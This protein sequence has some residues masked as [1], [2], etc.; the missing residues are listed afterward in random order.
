VE[1]APAPLGGFELAIE[2]LYCIT[3]TM[4]LVNQFPFSGLTPRVACTLLLHAVNSTSYGADPY[5]VPPPAG[6]QWTLTFDDEFTQDSS[7]DTN[8][9]IGG[10]GDSDLGG[11]T[12]GLFGAKTGAAWM[13]H[14]V[15]DPWGQHYD[16]CTL[17]R[18]NGLE[19]R[20]PGAPSAVLQTV[21]KTAKGAKFIQKFGYWEACIKQPHNTHGES[22]GMHSDFWMHP[23]PE[24]VKSPTEWLPEVDCG[25]RPTWDSNAD[26]ANNKMYFGIHDHG[27][28]YGGL[29]HLR[30]VKVSSFSTKF[31]RW[32]LS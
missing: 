30:Q 9:W 31:L 2:R 20:S 10:A 17:S 14:E 7:I 5:G 25:E 16:G 15:G 19:M 23:I 32:R 6:K 27:H 1:V 22:T 26:R 28:D 24:G 4:Q 13:F 18:T 29:A 21:G 12:G 11:L 3:H 8:R